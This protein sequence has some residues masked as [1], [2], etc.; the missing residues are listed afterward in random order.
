MNVKPITSTDW[1]LSGSGRMTDAQRRLMN[2]ACGDLEQMRWFGKRLSK[3]DWR[4][5][6]SGTVLGWR[7]MPGVDMGNGDRQMIM[8]GGSSLE[9]T[10]TQATDA[11]TMAFY[12][13]DAPHEQGLTCKPVAWC[14][15]VRMARGISDAD[16][17]LADRFAA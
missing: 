11:I 15:V 5:L 4:H 1:Q 17:Q 16:D 8:L 7:I 9:L 6:L 12:V 14:Y 3:D 2:A 10:R 13:G